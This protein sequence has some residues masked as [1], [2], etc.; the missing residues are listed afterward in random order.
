M[1]KIYQFITN[2]LSKI[3]RDK[4]LHFAVAMMLTIILQAIP[5]AFTREGSMW[6]VLVLAFAKE[7]FIDGYLGWGT[8]DVK[9]FIWSAFGAAIPYCAFAAEFGLV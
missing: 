4:L 5:T 1:K 8:Q 9:D 6:I 2:A 7:V 3:Q